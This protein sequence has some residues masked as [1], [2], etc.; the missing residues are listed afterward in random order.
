MH[1]RLYHNTRNRFSVFASLSLF[2]YL[3]AIFSGFHHRTLLS[4]QTQ[5]NQHNSPLLLLLFN[6]ISLHSRFSLSSAIIVG[7]RI[8]GPV[9]VLLSLAT[10]R[11]FVMCLGN[12]GAHRHQRKI[13]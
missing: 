11:L 1:T 10:P 4:A 3:W 13:N 8:Q 6:S 12:N 2:F 5:N 9:L 7:I